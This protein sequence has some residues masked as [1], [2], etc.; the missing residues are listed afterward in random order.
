MKVTALLD[1]GAAYTVVHSTVIRNLWLAPVD[2]PREALLRC[3]G[4][5]ER[6]E[7]LRSAVLTVPET[8][9]HNRPI[10][11]AELDVKSADPELDAVIGRDTLREFGL[12]YDGPNAT[13]TLIYVSQVS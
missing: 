1:T 9:V 3:L 8:K 7:P 11:V 13:V 10:E 5:A 4:G 12:L 6:H 2:P